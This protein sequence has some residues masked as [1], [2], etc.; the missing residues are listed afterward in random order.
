MKNT[1][2]FTLG[3]LFLIKVSVSAQISF[4]A[5][6]NQPVDNILSVVTDPTNGDLYACNSSRVLRSTDQGATWASTASSGASKLTVLYF[7]ASGQLYLGAAKSNATPFVGLFTY[8]STLNKWSPV[9]GSP[10]NITAIIENVSGNICVGTGTADNLNPFPMS[11][12][13]GVYEYVSG[14][15]NQ[16][17]TGMSN[18]TGFSVL[19]F[20]K[21][22]SSLSNGDLLAATYG[23][24]VLQYASGSW[25]QYGTGLNDN[26]VNSLFV[27]STDKVFAGTDSGV[28]TTT[29]GAWVSASSGLTS[30]KPVRALVGN[31]SGVVYAGLGFYHYQKGDIQG[32]FFITNDQ[33]T[34]WQ[35]SS[36]G[37]NSTSVLSLA[38]GSD[39][40][41]YGGAAGLWAYKNSTWSRSIEGKLLPTKISK[42]AKN[43]KGDLFAICG[44]LGGDFGFGGVYRSADNG[45]TWT[46]INNGIKCHGLTTIFVDQAD[47][48]WLGGNQFVGGSI[49]N[50]A[51]GN[52][53]LY[54]STDNGNSWVQNTSI[55]TCH[56]GY[57]FIQEDSNGRLY[58]SHSF[59]AGQTNISATDDYNTFDNTLTGSSAAN[60]SGKCYG[61]GV[62]PTNDVFVGV[63]TAYGILRS[64][65][66]GAS[67]S[68]SPI[69]D[70]NSSTFTGTGPFGNNS[71]YI[72]PTNGNLF[73]GS[74]HGWNNGVQSPKN[75]WC[76]LGA[77][78]NSLSIN[79]P[80]MFSFDNLPD[81]VS[82]T[83][84]ISDSQGN[85]Y[86]NLNS[87]NFS[88]A[89]LYVASPPY[90]SST[91]F[92]RV[93]SNSTFSYYFTG[94]MIDDCGYMISN[95]NVSGGGMT[96]SNAVISAPTPPKL[97]S[98]ATTSQA[99]SIT[100]TLQWTHPCSSAT[101][102]LQVATDAKFS[103]V[104]IDQSNISGLSQSINSGILAA[105]TTYYWRVRGTNVIGDS[106]WSSSFDFTTSAAGLQNQTITFSALPS[107]IL[108]DVPF[109]LTATGGASG[110]AVTF[111][112]SDT[113]VATIAGNTVT[114]VG[115]GTTTIT[116]SQA[117]NANF[118]AAADVQQAL[119]VDKNSQTISFQKPANHEQGDIFSLTASSSSNLPLTYQSSNTAIAS[120]NG[121]TLTLIGHG[122]VIITVSQLGDNNYYAAQPVSQTLTVNIK[123]I[124][125]G[126]SWNNL[127]DPWQ[128][129]GWD[130]INVQINGDYDMTQENYGFHA[131]K[132]TISNT[133][134]LSLNNTWILKVSDTLRI[135][136]KI[137][138]INGGGINTLGP[139]IG[140]S[141]TL[142]RR[143]T[144]NKNTGR[145]SVIGTPVASSN[146]D[147]LGAKALIYGYDV[148]EMYNINGDQG[149]SRFKTPTELNQNTLAVG[150]GYFSAYTGDNLGNVIFKGKPNTGTLD[151]PL[152]YN[153]HND[154]LEVA[155]AGF[156]L[157]SNPY[158]APLNLSTF[159]SEN[160]N[161]DFTGAIYLW[162]DF[163]SNGARGNNS[164]YLIANAIGNTD[165]R[166]LGAEKWD[167]S[168]RSGQ[169]FFVNAKSNTTLNFTNE[170]KG[171]LN[172][173][174]NGFF[175][176]ADEFESV[177]LVLKSDIH[178]QATLIGFVPDA[179]IDLDKFYD[180][181]IFGD[182]PMK[183]YTLAPNDTRLSIQGLPLDFSE[184]I[185]LGYECEESGQ[186]EI[187][188]ISNDLSDNTNLLLDNFLHKTFDLN[189]G[190]Y[191]F[192]SELG[193]YTN[194]FTI[195]RN[196]V[197]ITEAQIDIL[198]NIQIFPNPTSNQIKIQTADGS[199]KLEVYD[200]TGKKMT[201]SQE[202]H[203]LDISQL[204]P[205]SYLLRLVTEKA[206]YIK[207][208]IKQ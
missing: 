200:I 161:C 64:T 98:P 77:N 103:N 99:T 76:A 125:D 170:M 24:G 206:T 145:Y 22:F 97:Q 45:L 115:A 205:G 188:K 95:Y 186:Y 4:T 165:S 134:T 92:T 136:G 12:G 135:D 5:L 152:I 50:T 109:T 158:P 140:D 71:I 164:D 25:S 27:N 96:K 16:I 203:M 52:P 84:M 90:T 74:T 108:G 87:G 185:R 171:S 23:N 183:F 6:P 169:G 105:S 193:V 207:Q 123:Y 42:V 178:T 26:H 85:I 172:N 32:I 129:D 66:N 162:D 8:N 195:Q 55:A 116:A 20:I 157:V 17:N 57:F 119:V 70:N 30:G 91:T 155:Q 102:E 142:E 35:N 154:P 199:L 173:G 137:H 51:W 176:K 41:L 124:W 49:S 40:T 54:K 117:G 179:T 62:S 43:S 18:L 44:N 118:Y 63:E 166:S 61:L 78:A 133:A 182:R 204:M 34:S 101:F 58:V 80:N 175:R 126:Q 190:N 143:T 201:V 65:S 7:S 111:A 128:A 28:S 141:L 73:G 189:E 59:F 46:S 13:A 72:D 1:S 100:P 104:I 110:N 2:I 75:V 147:V 131:K 192:D 69:I 138:I 122:D 37:F 127:E 130:D 3:L 67:G 177:K 19:P 53:E 184:P 83:S 156:N 149:L 198:T 150:Q 48:I 47:N 187:S 36:N 160:V 31:A 89:G 79:G 144:F 174:D 81:Y 68:F 139:V 121:S 38:F 202:G 148:N 163:G 21:A 15:W 56:V 86:L 180:A 159:L 153:D 151:V 39:G 197:I 9:A 93:I 113:N 191:S 146:F 14:S 168:I 181:E 120:F 167:G 112:S 10:Q 29:G 208:L 106:N 82:M 132:L 194:R 33:G 11:Y 107:K 114:I 196:D 88:L 60:T 94:L